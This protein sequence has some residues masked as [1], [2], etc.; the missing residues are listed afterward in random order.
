M[1]KSYVWR[2]GDPKNQTEDYYYPVVLPLDVK[3]SDCEVFR[4]QKIK[5]ENLTIQVIQIE[6]STIQSTRQM[7]PQC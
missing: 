7:A 2:F 5:I 1:L 3:I 4:S 6:D